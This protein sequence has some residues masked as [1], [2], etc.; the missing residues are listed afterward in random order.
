MGRI[1]G[2]ELIFGMLIGL[3]IFWGGRLFGGRGGGELMYGWGVL[4]E[5]Y[6]ICKGELVFLT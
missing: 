4:M 6:G 5:F 3:H 2:R 1:Y